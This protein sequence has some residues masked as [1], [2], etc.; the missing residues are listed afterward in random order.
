MN[1]KLWEASSSIKKN[2][3][4]YKFEK[5]IS[6]KSN[7]N[8]K[9]NYKKLFNW[10]IKNLYFFWSLIWDFTSVKGNKVEKFKY[11]KEF[12]KNKFF[13]NSKLNFAENLLSIK[14]NS[15]AITFISENGYK[16]IRSWKNLNQNTSKLINFFKINKISK[17]DRVAAYTANQI[18]TVECFLAT[19]SI[20]AIWSSCSSD[21]IAQSTEITDTTLKMTPKVF[22]DLSQDDSAS[23]ASLVKELRLM[24]EDVSQ[25]L[26]DQG[27][28]CSSELELQNQLIDQDKNNELALTEDPSSEKDQSNASL[29]PGGGSRKVF[30][31]LRL[32]DEKNRQSH[33]QLRSLDQTKA[34]DS[35]VLA[36]RRFLP[37][38]SLLINEGKPLAV[39][40]KKK[41]S[42]EVKINPGSIENLTR[43]KNLL[44]LKKKFMMKF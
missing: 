15:K 37:E 6:K 33:C 40:L 34:E 14:D 38:M 23:Q 5:F 18:E 32:K 36:K 35:L 44:N 43:P 20:G 17:R 28:D 7:Y 41:V 3:N 12:I 25:N 13:V 1:K 4:L 21:F 39:G 11:S 24:E 8:P 26:L 19:A 16:E 27:V 30:V 10:S 9:K 31:Y 22:D 2:S 29:L 42:L